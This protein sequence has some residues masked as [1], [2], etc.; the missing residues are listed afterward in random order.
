MDLY[1][2]SIEMTSVLKSLEVEEKYQE[3]IQL[4]PETF[5]ETIHK[6][7]LRGREFVDYSREIS[8][9][10]KEVY[11]EDPEMLIAKHRTDTLN[12]RLRKTHGIDKNSKERIKAYHST[13]YASLVLDS[14][15]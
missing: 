2:D 13:K 12:Y 4:N 7:I 1:E 9:L 10:L 15:S 6:L 8:L 3:S 14:S 5:E 11:K